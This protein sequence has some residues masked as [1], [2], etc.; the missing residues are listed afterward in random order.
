MLCSCRFSL[1]IVFIA[2]KHFLQVVHNLIYG[3]NIKSITWVKH[4]YLT[5]SM[6]SQTCY[7]NE[8]IIK[9]FSVVN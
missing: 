6:E 1:N 3:L 2:A 4:L 5:K 9:T 7:W 8:L